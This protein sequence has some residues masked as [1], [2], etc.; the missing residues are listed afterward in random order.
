MS[1]SDF[2]RGASAHEGGASGGTG[3]ADLEVGE[4]C[5]VLVEL[6]DVGSSDH[7]VTHAGK[8]AH[9]LVIG[10]DDDDIGTRAFER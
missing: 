4:A 8:V 1:D 6:V 10:D 2:E 3:R 5:R 9:A 7:F